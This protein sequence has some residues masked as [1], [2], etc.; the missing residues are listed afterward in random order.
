MLRDGDVFVFGCGETPEINEKTI[1]AL[2]SSRNCEGA[3]RAA[4]TR[5]VHH[6][7]FSDGKQTMQLECPPKGTV[8]TQPAGMGIYMGD[9]TYLLGQTALSIPVQE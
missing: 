6:L 8:I 5:G 9:I 4:D 1:W 2:Y 3:W 7:T